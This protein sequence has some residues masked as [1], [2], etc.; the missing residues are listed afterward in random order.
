MVR[1]NHATMV[2][3]RVVLIQ[4]SSTRPIISAAMAKAYGT[5][6]PT[7]P[8]YSSGGCVI[9]LESSSNGLSPRPSSGGGERISNGFEAKASTARK[10]AETVEKMSKTQGISSRWRSL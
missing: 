9:M 8:V 2:Q 7:K 4:A 10:K 1:K 3:R 5:V 6:K